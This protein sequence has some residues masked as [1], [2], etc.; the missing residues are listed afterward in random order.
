MLWGFLPVEFFIVS[1]VTMLQI[2]HHLALR[3][4]RLGM[5]T[6]CRRFNDLGSGVSLLAY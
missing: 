4:F 3:F 6:S 5:L 1:T 2:L